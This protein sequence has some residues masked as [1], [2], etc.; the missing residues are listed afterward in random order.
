MTGIVAVNTTFDGAILVGVDMT[1]LANSVSSH[2]S[3]HRQIDLTINFDFNSDR[4]TA[5]GTRQ[6][7][8]IAHALQDRSLQRSR[9]LVEG[10]TDNV[11]TDAYNQDLSARRAQRVLYALTTDYGIPASRLT[12]QGFGK[13]RPIASNETDLGRAVNRR[14]TL[15]NLSQ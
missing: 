1:E 12:A 3:A 10:H 4:L 15:I 8:E 11:G 2:P 9:I 7:E 6:V 14:V 5:D 13:T